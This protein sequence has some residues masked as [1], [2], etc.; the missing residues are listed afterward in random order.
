VQQHVPPSYGTPRVLYIYH[1]GLIHRETRILD[2]DKSTLL[3][4]VKRN[5]KSCFSS[6]PHTIF[7]AA[8]N[9]VVGSVSFHAFS[10]TVDLNVHGRKVSLK[11]SSMWK[12][13]REFSSPASGSTFKWKTDGMFSGGDLI[14]LDERQQA[15]ARFQTSMWAVKKDGKFEVAPVVTRPTMD[16]LIVSGIAMIEERRRRSNAAAGGGGD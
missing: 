14:C 8:N 13:A 16:E 6:K 9:A 11:A 5:S 15:I 1:S 2:S 12:H 10:R 7:Y 4:T 3:Y